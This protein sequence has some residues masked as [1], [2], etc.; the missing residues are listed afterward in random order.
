MD[1]QEYAKRELEARNKAVADFRAIVDAAGTEGRDLTPE[2]DTRIAKFE[3]E[4]AERDARLA[5]FDRMAKAEAVQREQRH[6]ITA[7]TG[8]SEAQ[9]FEQRLVENVRDIFAKRS[10]ASVFDEEVRAGKASF[11]AVPLDWEIRAQTTTS[12]T[13]AAIVPVEYVNQ[14]AIYARTLSPVLGLA[15]VINSTNGQNMNLPRLT[16]DPTVYTPGQGTAITP[17]DPTISAETLVVTSYKAL[18][19]ISQELA[20][21]DVTGIL[22]YTA[23]VQGRAIGLA[24]GTDFVTGANGYITDG[25]N[26]GTAVG[27]PFF[28]L[29]DLINLQYSAA[30]PYRLS[31]SWTMT[32]TAISKARKFKDSNGQYLW[33]PAIELGQPDILL[34]RPVYEDPALATVA[35]ASKSV[36]F[37]DFS[38]YVI[39][40][41]P[42]RV[43]TSTEYLFNTDQVAIKVVY[44]AGGALPDVAAIRYLVSGNS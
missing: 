17:S 13:G 33:Q 30:A 12:A 44:R 39:K 8:S 32:N 10:A 11:S 22:N 14:I 41:L 31:G 37:G 36:A 43:A 18:A 26:G 28:D 7:G 2:E 23:R 9:T 35:S 21:D 25:T 5:Q 6:I 3:A 40:Q 38:A 16:A 1:T 20:E 15:T 27:T 4:V 19:L 24:A 34:G 42:L 29:D